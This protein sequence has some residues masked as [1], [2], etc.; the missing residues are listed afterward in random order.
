VL[1]QEQYRTALLWQIGLAA[2]MQLI[3]WFPLGRWNYQPCCPPGLEALRRGILTAGDVVAAG[4][5]LLPVALWCALGVAL[6]DV[7]RSV[8]HDGLAGSAALD[9][10]ATVSVRGVGSLVA[11]LFASLCRID[12]DSAPMGQPSASGRG[13]FLIAGTLSWDRND[14][15]TGTPAAASPEGRLTAD[16]GWYENAPRAQPTGIALSCGSS[17]L[18][19][20]D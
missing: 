2:Y 17:P 1:G 14:G 9:M 18:P 13:T 11:S 10:V 5:F 4:A 20:Y 7:A 6:G 15:G 16:G 19:P 8:G 3:S 12:A